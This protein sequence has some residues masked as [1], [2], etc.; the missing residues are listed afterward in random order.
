MIFVLSLI[1]SVEAHALTKVPVTFIEALAPRD[2]TS[3]EKFKADFEAAIKL[4][5]DLTSDKLNKCGYELE[6]KTSFYDASDALQAKELG[7]AEEKNGTWLLVGPRRSNH[8][9]AM[10]KGADKTSSVSLM[11][12]SSEVKELGANHTT[13]AP[14][15]FELAEVAAKEAARKSKASKK[16]L[17]I[18]NG[19]CLSCVDFADAFEKKANSLGL[20]L[21]ERVVVTGEK[22]DVTTAIEKVKS[23]NPAFILIPNYSNSSAFMMNALDEVFKGFYVGGDGWGDSKFGFVQ[24][25]TK[26]DLVSGFAVR[27]FPPVSEGVKSLKLG[28]ITK[29]PE[30]GPAL[31]VLKIIEVTS[32][33]LCDSK[34]KDKVGFDKVFA[35]KSNG[36]NSPW[37]V[38]I[39]DLKNG[40][41]VF[42]KMIKK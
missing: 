8:Y 3:S 37:G 36:Y 29:T 35:S 12:T 5:K 2:S 40:E 10:V 17:S 20:K 9:I 4:G 25:S 27:G 15:N 13:V 28:K 42:R 34:P 1:F 41:I 7:L 23:E 31:A 30:S 18:V 19:D 38:S 11:A 14:F 16:Y 39:Y 22:P 21:I 24:K 32:K 33:M 6:T 26:S